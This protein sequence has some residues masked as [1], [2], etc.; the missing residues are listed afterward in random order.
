MMRRTLAVAALVGFV[1]G[2]AAAN[3]PEQWPARY[4]KPGVTSRQ[5]T[6]DGAACLGAPARPRTG[7]AVGIGG[8]GGIGPLPGDSRMVDLDSHAE[9]MKAKG[10][11]VTP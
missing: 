6:E 4:H 1:T 5:L 10:Y 3:G 2:C 9:C 8:V 11:T 7:T